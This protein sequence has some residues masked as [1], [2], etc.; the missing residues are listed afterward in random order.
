V[1]VSCN[2][3]V[4]LSSVI[5]SDDVSRFAADAARLF[6]HHVGD[7]AAIDAVTLHGICAAEFADCK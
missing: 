3:P 2:L 1:C 6:H 5:S 4:Q 7:A